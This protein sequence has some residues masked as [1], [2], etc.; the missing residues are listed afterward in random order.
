MAAE[1]TA[2]L[3]L[4]VWPD[5][6]AREALVD[7]QRRWSWPRGARMTAPDRLHLTMHFIGQVPTARIAAVADGLPVAFEPF[8]LGFSRPALW[9]AGLA[10]AM[11]ETVPPALT[12][13]HGRLADALQALALPVE[14][15]PYK[16]H[17]TLAR[18]AEGAVPPAEPLACCWT[19]E[20]YALVQSAG[21]YRTLRRYP[22]R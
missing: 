16:P 4:A 15:R 22:A 5:A 21:G 3:F 7:W 11:P 14:R 6:A 10:L 19:A 2:R 1:P 17:L 12:A 8:E 9:R 18:D 13:L 20:A